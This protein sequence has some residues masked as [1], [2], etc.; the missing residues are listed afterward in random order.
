M[1]YNQDDVATGP[2]AI[3]RT[4][5][6]RNDCVYMVHGWGRKLPGLKYANGRG[7]SD[8]DLVTRYKTD[9]IMGGTGMNVNYVR[10]ER[11]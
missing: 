4:R 9:P 10:M 5:R 3:R 7:T 8:S 1:V 2:V 11:A 6:I